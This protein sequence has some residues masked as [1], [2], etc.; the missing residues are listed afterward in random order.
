MEAQRAKR[1]LPVRT[2][3]NPSDPDPLVHTNQQF[4]KKGLLSHKRVHV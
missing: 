2:V 4:L 3:A 1:T